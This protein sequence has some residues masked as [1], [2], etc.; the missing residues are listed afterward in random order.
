M[1]QGVKGDGSL[2]AG[3]GGSGEGDGEAAAGVDEG[4]RAAAQTI[5]DAY[6]GI[7][8]EDFKGLVFEAFGA[9]GFLFAGEGFGVP[10]VGETSG[11]AAHFAWLAGDDA[12]DGSGAGQGEVLPPTPGLQQDLQFGFAEVGELL[13]QS[14]DSPH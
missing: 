9:A 10:A 4:E 2:T 11:G 12:A 8:G 13:A 5:S 14:A 7:A 3:L 1:T 6:Y